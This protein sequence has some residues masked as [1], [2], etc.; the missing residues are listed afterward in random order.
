M[1]LLFFLVFMASATFTN[2]VDLHCS[3]DYK[4]MYNGQKLLYCHFS[5]EKFNCSSYSMEIKTTETNDWNGCIFKEGES[6]SKITKCDCSTS[7]TLIM[8]EHL[9]TK[10]LRAGKLLNSKNISVRD[11]IKLKGPTITAV[12]PYTNGNFLVKWKTNYEKDEF[13]ID[14]I[15]K[16]MY[17]KK[18]E[19]DW[20]TQTTQFYFYEILGRDLDPNSHYIL[21][22]RTTINNTV[23]SSDASEE[24]DM[25]TSVSFYGLYKI[26]ITALIFI[27]VGFTCALFWCYVRFKSKW[28][29]IIPTYPNKDLFNIVPTEPWIL[30]LSQTTQC[31][32]SVDSPKIDRTEEKQLSTIPDETVQK[33]EQ[34]CGVDCDSTLPPM[35]MPPKTKQKEINTQRQ[36]NVIRE[37]LSKIFPNLPIIPVDSQSETYNNMTYS[38]RVN[39]HESR[40]HSTPKPELSFDSDY[41]FNENNITDVR[42]VIDSGQPELPVTDA[43]LLYNPCDNSSSPEDNSLTCIVY[44][45]NAP[46][47]AC[48]PPP[49][50][51]NDQVSQTL[52]KCDPAQCTLVQRAEQGLLNNRLESKISVQKRQCP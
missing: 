45:S 52:Q 37:A 15:T 3:T 29:D 17:K 46:T 25:T 27:A 23:I 44:K 14:L 2:G 34:G 50:V 51:E 42:T 43:N 35:H 8:G 20:V 38:I 49:S 1:C 10:L 13:G 48:S 32:I 30:S 26:V 39:S 41:H 12:E 19:K 4:R 7:M 24:R 16:L 36:I 47:P 31:P 9:T 40:R 22:V 33:H 11:S 21:T 28:W 6:S 18:G 5:S